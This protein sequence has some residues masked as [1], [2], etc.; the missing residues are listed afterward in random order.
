VIRIWI[1]YSYCNKI[2]TSDWNFKEIILIFLTR[3]SRLLHLL[4]RL[5][6]WGNSQGFP[7]LNFWREK[8]HSFLP[9][10]R[11]C[12]WGTTNLLSPEI[13]TREALRVAS[14]PQTAQQV[15]QSG[16]SGEK[17]QNNFFEIS[18]W[19]QNLITIWIFNPNSNHNKNIL[20][21]IWFAIKTYLPKLWSTYTYTSKL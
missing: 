10:P 17:N 12:S 2:L 8:V 18:I 4:C 13:E 7:R 9:G 11:V 19:S 5:R 14:F 15:E 3:P 1:K 20:M 16:R 6:K 21:Q